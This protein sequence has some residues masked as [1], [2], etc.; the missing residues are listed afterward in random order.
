MATTDRMD[1]VRRAMTEAAESLARE[2]ALGDDQSR[3]PT[4]GDLYVFDSAEDAALEWLVVREHPHDRD[5]LLVA[6]ADDFPLAGTPDVMLPHE[7][8]GRP[9]TARCGEAL[10]LPRG[11]CA[12]RLRVGTLPQEALS[13]V[14]RRLADLSRGRASGNDDQ[15][16][17]DLDPEYEYW[18][19]LVEQSRE[20]L[21][22]RV[23]QALVNLGEMVP[24]AL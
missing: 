10:W 11:W 19:G 23:D 16:Q 18:I 13:L 3:P 7:L 5:L 1:R 17:S 14:R 8:V 24:F 21:Q 6:P 20:L 9:L 15:R 4:P 2:P 22:R 12:P